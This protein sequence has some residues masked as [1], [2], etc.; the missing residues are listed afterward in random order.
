LELQ[1]SNLLPGETQTK[2]KVIFFDGGGGGGVPLLKTKE[3]MQR[4][5]GDCFQCCK[6]S[7]KVG[8]TLDIHNALWITM[9]ETKISIY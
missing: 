7:E 9:E 2:M 8:K 5:V 1:F 6:K 3:S 4:E